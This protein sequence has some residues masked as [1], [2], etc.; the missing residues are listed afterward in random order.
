MK[1]LMPVCLLAIFYGGCTTNSSPVNREVVALEPIYKSVTEVESIQSL[2]P[3]NMVKPG[4]IYA[5]GNFVFQAD[6]GTGIHITDI[7]NK[8]APVK[9]AFLSV[10]YCSEIAVK[11]NF[12]YANNLNDLV[13]FDITNPQ[14]PSL[15]KRSSNVFPLVSQLHPAQQNTYFVCPDP[16]KGL[17][18]GWQQRLMPQPNCRR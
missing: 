1:H 4:K 18:V 8:T 12:L 9:K 11:G 16:A 6:D 3:R 5:F 15:V 13:I 2:S 7:T 10:P 14:Q 17:V